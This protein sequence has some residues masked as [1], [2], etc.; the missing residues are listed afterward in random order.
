[1]ART[2]TELMSLPTYEERLEYLRLNGKAGEMTFGGNRYL[3][4]RLYNSPEWKR[5][6]RN[7]VLR[8]NGCDLACPDHPI[9]N[10]LTVHHL[11][12]ITIEDLK[13]GA[14]AVFDPENLVCVSFETHNDIHFSHKSPAP[15]V[16]NERTENDTAPWRCNDG[17]D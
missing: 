1:M 16:V 8:D 6:R 9:Y 11:E 14:A 3:N 12:P 5:L 2:Y 7:I 17:R 13:N 4:Q 15:P 10:K